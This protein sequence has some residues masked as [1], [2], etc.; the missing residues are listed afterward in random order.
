MYYFLLEC[1]LSQSFQH[2]VICCSF[3]NISITL[4]S[5]LCHNLAWIHMTS[6]APIFLLDCEQEIN[7]VY[8]VLNLCDLPDT[9]KCSSSPWNAPPLSH[10]LHDSDCSIF[11]ALFRLNMYVSTQGLQLCFFYSNLSVSTITLISRFLK[12]PLSTLFWTHSY[13]HLRDLIIAVASASL[14]LFAIFLLMIL[15]FL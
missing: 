7:G 11:G 12:R 4:P 3:L 6:S 8:T 5:H 2:W 9:A 1:T 13:A 10:I 14:K 15:P